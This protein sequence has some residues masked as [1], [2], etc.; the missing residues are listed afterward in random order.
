MDFNREALCANTSNF[1]DAGSSDGTFLRCRLLDHNMRCREKSDQV[2]IG[3]PKFQ[4]QWKIFSFLYAFS[5]SDDFHETLSDLYSS[6]LYAWESRPMRALSSYATINTASFVS[7]KS[8][9]TADVKSSAE[10][11]EEVV[12]EFDATK[13]KVAAGALNP[14]NYRRDKIWLTTFQ[15]DE[16]Q[17]LLCAVS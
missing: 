5:T 1:S 10:D 16:V 7:P 8:P 12:I 6:N 13:K 3:A 4:Q 11:V 15:V 2:F 14:R 9:V 17:S